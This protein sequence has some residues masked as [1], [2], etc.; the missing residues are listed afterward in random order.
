MGS[1]KHKLS[2]VTGYFTLSFVQTFAQNTNYST[3]LNVLSLMTLT[4]R[5][6]LANLQ[7]LRRETK[8]HD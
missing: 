6:E 2:S 5:G 4:L 1:T 8:I 3:H 7:E